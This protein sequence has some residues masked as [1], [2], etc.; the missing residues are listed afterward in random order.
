[1][2]STEINTQEHNLQVDARMMMNISGVHGKYSQ[3]A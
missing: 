1:M 2:V 3:E